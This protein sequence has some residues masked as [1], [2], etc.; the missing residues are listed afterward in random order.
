MRFEPTPPLDRERGPATGGGQRANRPAPEAASAQ[1]PSSLA[2]F[3][4]PLGR[5]LD[6]PEVTE[7]C[8]N[9]P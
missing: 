2:L 4:G 6:D 7:I 8:I 5:L 9:E 1:P 3:L